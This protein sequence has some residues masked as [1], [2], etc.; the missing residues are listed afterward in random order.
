VVSLTANLQGVAL[1]E[2]AEQVKAAVKKAGD[3]PKG[4]KVQLRGQIPALEAT[5]ENL[6]MGILLSLAAIFLLL[7]AFFQSFRV[8]AA[9]LSTAPA[10]LAG[11]A[12]ALVLTGTTLN[13]QSFMGT[14]MAT[15]IAVANAILV[16]SFAESARRNGA[17]PLDAARQG[18]TGRLR[19]ILMTATAMTAG[20]LPIALG[21]GEGGS[22]TAPLGRAV[23]GGLV[24]ATVATLTVLPAVYAV[25][26]KGASAASAS[27]DPNDP[28]SKWYEAN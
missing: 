8:S 25:L 14:V 13:V 20:M 19:A 10:V 24:A 22:Q 3:P 5:A 17:N 2:A 21:M 16:C 26:M 11:S 7:T 12:V 18:A 15:G 9:I 23:I 6:S 1:G 28:T 27:L 4:A